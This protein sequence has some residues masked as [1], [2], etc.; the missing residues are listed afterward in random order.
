[1]KE[2]S[3]MY[4]LKKRII[5]SVS[6]ATLSAAGYQLINQDNGL[7]GEYKVSLSFERLLTSNQISHLNQLLKQINLLKN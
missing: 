3:R 7:P 6:A 5:L 4:G 1:M 2:Q